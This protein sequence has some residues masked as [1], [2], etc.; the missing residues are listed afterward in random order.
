MQGFRYV[1]EHHKDDADWFMKADDDT[2]VILEN[3]RYFLI[4]VVELMKIKVLHRLA[5][6]F[7]TCIALLSRFWGPV[8][9]QHK[10]LILFSRSFA[11]K[12]GFRIMCPS[13]ATCLYVDCSG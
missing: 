5:H 11:T 7:F 8:I 12:S 4:F 13:G 10:I 1:Y 3:L 6:V 2:Y 9:I